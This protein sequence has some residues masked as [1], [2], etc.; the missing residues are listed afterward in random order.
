MSMILLKRIFK[1]NYLQNIYLILDQLVLK[2]KTR[3]KYK[4][5]LNIFKKNIYKISSAK[6]IIKQIKKI[7]KQK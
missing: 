1:I 4:S 5:I 6:K 3:K 2:I 7:N